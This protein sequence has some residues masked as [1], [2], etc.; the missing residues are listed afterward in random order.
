MAG[1]SAVYLAATLVL[2]LS[3]AV[4]VSI[5]LWIAISHLL[6]A[7]YHSS[8]GLRLRPLSPAG[9]LR[10][11]R[12]LLIATLV[13]TWWTVRAAGRG[14]LR[15]P[16]GKVT[17]PPVLCV[18]GF[19]RNARCMWGIQ[20]MLGRLGR[21]ALAVSMGRPFRPLER[22]APAL[23]AAL[24]ELV[25]AF[26]GERIDVVAHSM[27]G[28]VLRLALAEHSDLA[29]AVGRIVTLGSPH[30]G[31]AA[32]SGAA[33]SP[34]LRQL[35]PGSPFLES[36]PDFQASAPG[37]EVTTVAA[38]RDFIVYPKSTSHLPG[39]RAVDLAHSNHQSLLTESAVQKLLAELL[40]G[41]GNASE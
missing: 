7:R 35:E 14:G 2:T 10:C 41:P 30:R 11:Y 4:P 15:R 3:L 39:T 27:G 20:R 22:Y 6:F 23:E 9:I 31:T 8:R 21:P 5:T 28:V 12:R 17:G 37:A 26:P 18:H 16:A 38:E 19:F 33:F 34:E 1:M 24:R 13:V 40:A 32:V 29:A 36:L 25:A